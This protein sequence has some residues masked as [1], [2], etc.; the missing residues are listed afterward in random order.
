MTPFLLL[1]ELV[2]AQTDDIRPIERFLR[3][4]AE[5]KAALP[6]G[7]R[8]A[9]ITLP[10]NPRGNAMLDPADVY[11]L[12]A[13]RG[14]AGRGLW[15]DLDVI[16][17]ITGKEQ[18]AEALQSTLLGFRALGLT[19]VL[20]L[21]GDKPDPGKRV[22]E[23]DSI[24][25]LRLISS[26]NFDAYQRAPLKVL[27]EPPAPSGPK[28]PTLPDLLAGR[29]ASSA[30][31]AGFA[32]IPQFFAL[33]AVSPFKYTEA[34]LIQQ[35]FKL[36]KKIRAGAAAI[37]TQMGWDSRKSEELF[38]Y[39]RDAGLSVPVFGN[40]FYLTTT[41]QAARLMHDGQMPGCYVSDA[42]LADVRRGKTADHIERAA[43]QV[44]MYRD[45][46]AA[47]VDLGGL[48]DFDQLLK[49]T[50]RA[51][52][53][54]PGW[55]DRRAILDYPPRR[56]ASGAA[57][58]YLYDPPADT[59]SPNAAHPSSSAF[60]PA[61]RPRRIH[62][63]YFDFLHRNFL[64][65]GRCLNPAVTATAGA[66]PSLKRG[67]GVLYNLIHGA[68]NATKSLLFKCEDCGDCFLPENFGY[69]TLGECEKGLANPPCGD[70]TPDGYCGNNVKRVCVAEL[71][72]NA[73]AAAIV[74][75]RN[76][77]ESAP[78]PASTPGLARLASAVLPPRLP[79]LAHTSAV[80]NYLFDRDHT[81]AVPLI[82]IAELLHA[83]IPRTAAAMNEVIAAGL[84]D[85]QPTD[86]AALGYL[87]SLIKMQVLHGAAYIDVNVDALSE[88]D[89]E[90]R[91]KILRFFVRLIRDHS[92]GVPVCVDSGST[93]MLET[94]LEAWY[95]C[96]AVPAVPLLNSV[97]TYTM[98]RLLPLRSRFPFR[99][100]GLLV[101]EKTAGRD[102][103][104][105]VDELAS[106]ARELFT[107]ATGRYGFA[108]SDI[109]FDSTVFPLS[110][111][112]PMNEEK[113][114][115]TFRAFETIR[116]LKADPAY[117]GAHFSLG[118]T[119]SVRNLPG[120]RTGVTR[121]YLARAM[122][123]GL[124]AA[125][126]NV[127]HDYGRRPP[128]PDLLAFVDAFVRQDG[129]PASVQRAIDAMMD[130]CRANRNK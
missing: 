37:L 61:P 80:L 49:I 55:R 24:G 66:F 43:A 13:S 127:F 29:I 35:Y 20:A 46:G 72:Y 52:E 47:G 111:D 65:K 121:A 59:G 4:Y 41:N 7:V 19:S 113:P 6:S 110:I 12:L 116:R 107:A 68:E 36:G 96:A 105:G 99:F 26:L 109:F 70:A 125:I 123:R 38:R 90:F 62:Q 9:G 126:V 22:F 10:Q 92:F 40:V 112:V 3:D 33:A 17:H 101:D 88:D 119:N 89:L 1:A 8:L 2:P 95:E 53:I 122:E 50:A 84:K 58:F 106:L 45:L 81:R 56:L 83:S 108:P 91:K 23:L 87:V 117:K 124:D 78:P 100:I 57:P 5:R 21:T 30:P 25:L 27:T 93:D 86:S 44:A 74:E 97:K 76:S 77:A 51:E 129:A 120:R 16:P 60:R 85:P 14:P 18:N 15:S 64:T 130:F 114:G 118:V 32:S 82:Q 102:G 94:G 63:K 11:A 71:I 28:A 39:L 128:A 31:A 75:S 34:S 104:Y 115:Y 69:C 103:A 54:G 42:L 67:D 79:A 48:S 73:A 98:D